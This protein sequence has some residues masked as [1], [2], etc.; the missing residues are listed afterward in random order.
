MVNRRLIVR[1]CALVVILILA[2][3]MYF[4]GR[5][6]TI[7]VDNK[8][9]ENGPKALQSIEVSIDKQESL[10]LYPRDRDQFIVTG[11]SHTLHVKFTDS[12]W[13]EID[14]VIKFKVPAK[15][16]MYIISLPV[17]A[18][19]LDAPSSE[20]LDVFKSMAVQQDSSAEEPVVSEDPSAI[21]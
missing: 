14:K 7:L 1:I 4:I 3:S 15:N 8:S 12:N 9:V 17:L 19:N 21:M 2:L 20:W 11:Q 13:N 10:E 6:H 5:Q 18:Q 16:D